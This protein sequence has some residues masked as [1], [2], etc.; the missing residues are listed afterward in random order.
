MRRKRNR[1]ANS[2]LDRRP[3]SVPDQYSTIQAAI[4]AAKAGDTILVKAGVYH[5]AL[6]FKEGIELRGENRDTTIVRFSSPPTSVVGQDHYQ[7][8]LEIRG[9]ATG[10]VVNMGFEQD[11]TDERTDENVWMA[12]AD[13][14]V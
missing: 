5:E 3:R 14:I 7:I 8:P 9:C 4:D 13:R 6:K 2:Q 11:K 12:D 1:N 10:T